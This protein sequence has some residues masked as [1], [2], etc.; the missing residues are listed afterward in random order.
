MTP[1]PRAPARTIAPHRIVLSA[2]ALAILPFSAGCPV[3]SE[4]PDDAPVREEVVRETRARYYLYVPSKYKPDRP[5]PFVVLCHGTNPYDTAWYEIKEWAAFAERHGIIVAA[6]ELEGVRGDIPPPADVQLKYQRTDE[7]TILGCVAAI[8]AAYQVAEERIFLTGWSAGGYAVLHTGLRHPE[9]FRAL[10]V[11]QGNFDA[12]YMTE[13][14]S[15]LDRWQPVYI[16]YGTM[17]FVKDQ[18]RA[19]IEWLRDHGMHVDEM[20]IPGSH[21]RL[22]ASMAWDYFSEVARNRPWIRLNAV[23]PDYR[24]P[25]AIRLTIKS[26]PAATDALWN[27]GDGTEERGTAVLHEYEKEGVFEVMAQVKLESGK[28]YKRPISVRVPR[29]GLALGAEEEPAVESRHE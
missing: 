3:T 20:G 5:W 17:D 6:P 15:R 13:A 9:I 11:R 2:L 29:N 14:T 27:F 1:H 23:A 22:P 10:A 8:R 7:R 12:R 25:R 18:T 24:R 19:A 28:W 21:R 16:Y 4:L 26:I